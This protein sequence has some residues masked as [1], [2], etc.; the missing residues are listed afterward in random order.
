VLEKM[1]KLTK[2]IAT[3]GPACDSFEKIEELIKAGVNIFRFNFKHGT[4]D[5]H[6]ERIERVNKVAQKLGVSVGTLIDLQGPSL[7]VN[8]P[9]DKVEVKKG[10]L[11][12]FGKQIFKEK[13]AGIASTEPSLEEYLKEGDLVLIADGLF[14]FE[15]IKKEGNIYLKSFQ[16]GI[17]E[18]RKNLNVPDLDLPFSSLI[19]RDFEGLKLASLAEIDFVALS[20]VRSKEDIL[21]LRREME[22]Y[23]LNAKVISKIE[24][25]KALKNID[26][27]IDSSDGIMVARGDLGVEISL[28][29]VPY[30]QKE[31]INRCLTHGRLVITATQMFESMIKNPLPT[32]A[33][34]SDVANAV[35][36]GTD[37]L[38]LSAE[39]ATGSF[40][41]EAVSFM[42]KT[43]LAT[44][45]YL[46]KKFVFKFKKENDI[47]YSLT[48]AAA[49]IATTLKS[50]DDKLIGFLV[51]T[52]TGKTAIYLSR[53]HPLYPIF[54]ITPSKKAADYLTG[55][56]GVYPYVYPL[57]KEGEVSIVSIHKIVK[58]L[59]EK[60][61]LKEGWLVVL[62]GDYFGK[63]GGASTVRVVKV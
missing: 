21:I 16:D 20:F 5:W 34:V 7:R 57:E 52:E 24:T 27:I 30:W 48:A 2:I 56:F 22:K 54:A 11:Y 50:I 42:A 58:Y 28:E 8:L 41:V 55:Y 32:R 17:I 31:I 63:E 62:H 36:D 4:I 46:E 15:V 25:K 39:T 53:F 26:E 60:E 43:A 18:N 14:R 51:L 23:K 40:P 37:C 59:K 19:D 29:E 9:Y 6:K 12:P 3:I 44:E 49:N 61:G 47:V 1:K 33:E 13:V 35:Y 10:E 45:K 38:M